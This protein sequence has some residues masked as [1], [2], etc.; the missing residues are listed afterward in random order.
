MTAVAHDFPIARRL[1]SAGRRLGL[2]R[3][4]LL[5]S[6]RYV[7]SKKRMRRAFAAW[8]PS[9][10]DVV[11]ATFMKSGTNWMMQ[12]AAQIAHRGAAEFDHIHDLV[13]W[14]DT[15]SLGPV[16]LSDPGP[17]AR[18]PTGLRVIKTHGGVDVVPFDPAA[19]YVVVLRDPKEVI[20]SAYHFA[21]PLLG[22][23]DRVDPPLWH[24]LFLSRGAAHWVEHTAGWWA[25]RHEP[26]VLVVRFA[27]MKADL[28][29]VADRVAAFMEVEL[30]AAERAAVLERSSFRW[31]KANNDA[32]RPTPVPFFDPTT[33]PPMVRR[34][35]AGGAGELYD[36]TQLAALD[37]SVLRQIEKQR[38]D[39]PY[40]ELFDVAP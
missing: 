25:L 1:Y 11:I 3:P 26:N 20:V 33:V 9:R 36:A 12:L 16:A 4:L 19:R 15:P 10:S 18:A 38:V 40:A 2:I 32:F 14:P 39:L 6:G 30:T 5:M 34:G 24:R 8:E 37:R 22:L 29:A 28:G 31:M 35:V 17:V 7:D 27:E 21:L 13:P 23:D